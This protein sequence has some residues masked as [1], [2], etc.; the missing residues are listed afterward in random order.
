VSF[1]AITLW[2]A[3]RRVITK[4]CLY[5]VIDSVRK[6][7]DTHSYYLIPNVASV[8]LDQT[9]LLPVEMLRLGLVGPT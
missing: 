3:S 5:F 8:I 4:V 1:A 6:L 2:F 9:V 7:L